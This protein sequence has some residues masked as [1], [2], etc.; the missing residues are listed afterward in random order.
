MTARKGALPKRAAL[1]Y[2]VRQELADRGKPSPEASEEMRRHAEASLA[3]ARALEA[4]YLETMDPVCV[5]NALVQIDFAT[6]I[7]NQ[8]I[9]LPHW[10][11]A[12]LI[13][14]A[15]Q[16]MGHAVGYPDGNR[17]EPVPP[18]KHPDGTTTHYSDHFWGL[19]A[20]QRREVFLE[21]LGFKGSGGKNFLQ[22]ARRELERVERVRQD[23]ALR[24]QGLSATDA[25]NNLNDPRLKMSADPARK[26]RH[27]R[28]KLS[29]KN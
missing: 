1:E 18:T 14:A 19:T 16:I 2:H 27:D 29:G 17:R 15:S 23:E 24:G 13:G 8:R 28:R 25:A 20:A 5:W 7:L 3:S 11:L 21:S 10:V 22:D 4:R 26:I 6:R 9:S 12:Y